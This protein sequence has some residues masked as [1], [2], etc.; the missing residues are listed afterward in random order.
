MLQVLA[1]EF[2]E[3]Y[4]DTCSPEGCIGY[5]CTYLRQS[6]PDYKISVS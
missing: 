5:S 4:R 6:P 3:L 2:T 1:Y